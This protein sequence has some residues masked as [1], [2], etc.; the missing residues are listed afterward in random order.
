[1]LVT[2]SFNLVWLACCN[3]GVGVFELI[4][5]VKLGTGSTGSGGL[6]QDGVIVCFSLLIIKGLSF[7]LSGAKS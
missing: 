7:L 1:M 5:G 4:D 3:S 2:A 6:G